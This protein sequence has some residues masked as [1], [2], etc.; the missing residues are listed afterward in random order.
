[1]SLE[2]L[3][4]NV[5]KICRDFLGFEVLWAKGGNQPSYYTLEYAVVTDNMSAQNIQNFIKDSIRP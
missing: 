5:V 4:Y 2:S 1:M 3:S